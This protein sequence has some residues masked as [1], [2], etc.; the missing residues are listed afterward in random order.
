VISSVN[1]LR[2][3]PGDRRTLCNFLRVS[4]SHNREHHFLLV[5]GM[6]MAQPQLESTEAELIKRV[7]G[8][9]PQAFEELLRPYER[10][11]YATAISILR[12]PADAEEVAQEAVLKAFSKLSSFRGESRFSTWLVQ[13]TYNEARMKLRKERQHLYESIDREQ[14]DQEGEYWPRDFADWR[15]IPSELLEKKEVREALQ[16][17]IN[18]LSPMYRDIVI[19]RDVQN[20]NLK[21]TAAVLGI[22]EGSVKT[23]LHRAR[24]QLRDFLAPGIDGSWSSG[25]NYRK[26]RPW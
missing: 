18:S 26:V 17:G 19:L 6:N 10:L 13:I 15:P 5:V 23:R 12:N 16:N 3:R 8:G 9:E 22:P 4:A 21:D 25:Q 1:P 14:Q 11:V 24:L 7:C 2:T 20:L